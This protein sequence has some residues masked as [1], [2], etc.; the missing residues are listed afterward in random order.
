MRPCPAC[1]RHVRETTCP[2]C[3]AAVAPA[4]R[5]V[6]AGHA[7]RAAI[8]SALAGCWTGNA[9]EPQHAGDDTTEQR[10]ADRTTEHRTHGDVAH[11]RVT[12]PGTGT[13]EGTVTDTNPGGPAA[14]AQVQLFDSGGRIAATT[15]T[16]TDGRYRFTALP[17]GS[18]RVH[19]MVRPNH[20]RMSVAMVELLVAV[21]ADQTATADVQVA[22]PVYR[23]NPN[24]TP[25]PYGA[26]PARRRIV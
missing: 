16:Q 14:Y 8:F 23:Y 24:Q 6:F 1:A 25:M 13:L 19:V 15:Q 11:H 5:A 4:A 17:P 3:G 12:A 7:T 18:Y 21:S 26:P 10:A 9:P 22:V 2:F 20:P